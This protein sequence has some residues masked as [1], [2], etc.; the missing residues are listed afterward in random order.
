MHADIDCNRF[1]TMLQQDS[2]RKNINLIG[3]DP[4]ILQLCFSTDPQLAFEI[5]HIILSCI[6]DINEGKYVIKL[7][8][9]FD[10]N[11]IIKQEKNRKF[12]PESWC[13]VIIYAE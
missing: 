5:L 1:P 8:C 6:I 9:K 10:V 7:W 12:A 3:T 2:N 11:L 13:L 4:R